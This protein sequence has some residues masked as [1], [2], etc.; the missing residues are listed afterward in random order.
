MSKKFVLNADDLGLTKANNTGILEGYSGGILKS[1]S[2]VP[3]GDAFDEAVNSVIPKCPQLGVGVHLNV[4]E[5]KSLSKGLDLLTDENGSFNNLY[6]NFIIK[7]YSNSNRDFIEQLEREFREQ[8]KKVKNAGITIT[9]IDSHVHVHAIPPIFELVCKL[10]REYEI[11]QIRTQYEKFYITPDLNFFM[12]KNYYINLLKIALLNFFTN[13]NK[14]IVSKYGL[15][16][17]D[18]IIGVGYT[19]MMTSLTVSSGLSKHKGRKKVVVEALIHPCR[20]EDGTINNN[21]TEYRLTKNE[22]LLSKINKMGFEV[23][24][25]A[26]K[27]N[28]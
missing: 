1:A 15:K 3:N 13:K 18:Y 28:D 2:L 19:S 6:L 20:Y 27:E 7:S 14:P 26:Q 17:N 16:T 10:A 11:P 5:G 8:I 12:D 4:I 9:H 21:F 22:K 25:Y 23:G 24:N